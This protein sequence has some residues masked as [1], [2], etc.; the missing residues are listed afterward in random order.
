MMHLRTPS[1]R[2]RRPFAILAP[3][4]LGALLLA[5]PA[6]ADEDAATDSRSEIRQLVERRFG[7]MDVDARRSAARR[8]GPM[9][10]SGRHRLFGHVFAESLTIEP[11][12]DVEIE[13]GTTIF[14]TGDITIDAPIVTIRAPISEGPKEVRQAAP[15]GAIVGA[16]G[17]D[18]QDVVFACDQGGNFLTNEP[19]LGA[20]G[21]N[22]G[23]VTLNNA[24]TGTIGIGGAGGKGTGFI[25]DCPG[26]TVTVGHNIVPGAGGSGGV[27]DV[28]G[29]SGLAGTGEDGASVT[30]CGG[31]GGD[32]GD[33]RIVAATIV[34]PT[35]AGGQAIGRIG[36]RAG[37]I[38]G[39]AAAE[40]GDGANAIFCNEDFKEFPGSGGSGDAEAGDAGVSTLGIIEVDAIV[41]DT[42][43][44]ADIVSF[45]DLFEFPD[46]GSALSSGGDGGIAADCIP[47]RTPCPTRGDSG[48]QGGNG[49]RAFALAGNGGF[50]GRIGAGKGGGLFRAIQNGAEAPAGVGG[51]ATAVGGDGGGGGNGSLGQKPGNGGNGGRGGKARAFGGA[52]GDTKLAKKAGVTFALPFGLLPSGNG[53]GAVVR[54]GDGGPG[55][56]GGNCCNKPG[57]RGGKAGKGG[58]GGGGKARAGKAGKA[59]K[60]KP[61]GTDGVEDIEKRGASGAPGQAGLACNKLGID[62]LSKIDLL[63]FDGS[64]AIV[65]ELFLLDLIL[66]NTA[67]QPIA[68]LDIEIRQGKD[69]IFF[70]QVTIPAA[71][72]EGPA[73]LLVAAEVIPTKAGKKGK[74]TVFVNGKKGLKKVFAVAKADGGGGG[75]GCGPVQGVGNPDATF[76]I[77]LIGSTS[78]PVL[79]ADNANPIP[80]NETINVTGT[81]F[82]EGGAVLMNTNLQIKVDGVT[83]YDQTVAGPV[84]KLTGAPGATFTITSAGAGCL[85]LFVDGILDS[86][87]ALGTV[88]N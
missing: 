8:A 84:S 83:V 39:D 68:D 9:R 81:L 53:G 77:S 10:L 55:G 27:G 25:I 74:F 2:L 47:L 46:G 37:G 73:E 67:L 59:G 87:R 85:E 78:G 30:G 51:S 22:G 38:G 72:G 13:A 69:Q 44:A 60:G 19:I 28:V 33:V 40:G 66:C 62:G 42:F 76:S 45:E 71:D 65:G 75:G 24:V 21:G 3:L 82:A 18:S 6:S 86:R 5:P 31:L 56:N 88:N 61:S 12:A 52:G 57:G 54:P 49:G 48:S 43:G 80:V 17:A 41:P 32:A 20:D 50:G 23:N 34:F 14:V 29:V 70:S 35:G 79:D 58:G 64:E 4:V 7:D 15:A 16:A 1:W 36:I 63:P 26:G 11:G